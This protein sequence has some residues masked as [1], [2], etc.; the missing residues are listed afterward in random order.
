MH[1]PAAPNREAG[2]VVGMPIQAG[3]GAAIEPEGVAFDE[4]IEIVMASLR[5]QYGCR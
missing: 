3:P 2:G 4:R 1:T 5:I